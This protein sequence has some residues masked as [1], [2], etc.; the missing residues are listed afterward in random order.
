MLLGIARGSL[1]SDLIDEKDS[2][3]NSGF[4][5]KSFSEGECIL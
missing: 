5:E 4:Y 2:G 1:P 3:F